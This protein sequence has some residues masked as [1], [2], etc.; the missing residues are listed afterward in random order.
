VPVTA[1]NPFAAALRQRQAQQLE[2]DQQA[3]RELRSASY[4][5]DPVG[6]VRD[7]TREH[8]TAD[9]AAVAESVVHNR[10][11]AVRA[12]HDSGKSHIASRLAAWWLDTHPLGEAFVVTTAPTAAQ[13]RV[14]LW[15]EIGKAHKLAGLFG[16]ITTGTVPEW[17]LSDGEIVAYGR[18]PADYDQAAFQ[19]IHARYVLIIIDEGSGVPASLFDAADTLATNQAARVLVIGNPDDPTSHFAKVCAPGSGWN[20]LHIDGLATPNMTADAVARLPRLAELFDQLG[21]EP[22]TEPVPDDLRPMLLSPLWVEERIQRWGV[23]S[24]LFTAKVRGVFPDVGEDT[25]IPPGLIT[26]AQLRTL[27]PGPRSVLS[28]DVARFGTDRT[29]IGLAD[30]PVARILGSYAK[31][32]TTETTGRVVAALRDTRADEARVDGVGVG[33]GVVDQLVEQGFD[34][35]DMQSGAAA[36]DSEHFKNARAEWWWGLRERFEAGDID[37]DPDDDELA[38]Q[39]GSIKYKYTARGQIQIESKDDMRKRGLPSPD[40]ADTV[41]QAYAHV[42]D[43]GEIVEPDEFDDEGQVSISAY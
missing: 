9:Q 32:A 34:V 41:M 39:L 3:Q 28:V 23:E 13:V 40:H 5:T 36:L 4:L 25:L 11:T 7:F 16:Y 2:R 43:L 37:I 30:G 20:V 26:A 17:K 6:W 24:P 18:K 33:G 38:A 22:S 19:G 12:C 14:I 1:A 8:L 31:Q 35:V 42:P 27:E 15:R 21:L 29:V 10:Y